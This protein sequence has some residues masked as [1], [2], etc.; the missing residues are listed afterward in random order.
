MKAYCHSSADLP[1][2]LVCIFPRRIS[3][4][5]QVG[6]R[7]SRGSKPIDFTVIGHL[8]FHEAVLDPPP[9]ASLLP[10]LSGGP[11]FLPPSV[12]VDYDFFFSETLLYLLFLS[13][14]IYRPIKCE[15]FCCVLAPHSPT[16]MYDSVSI[17]D[18]PIPFQSVCYIRIKLGSGRPECSR[19]F[20][21]VFCMIFI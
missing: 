10:R 5:A 1:L 12:I 17:I 4:L 15:A 6:R 11:V 9:L 13:F 3:C 14:Q 18:W 2:R 19:A 16:P 7:G 8:H 21:A 20:L